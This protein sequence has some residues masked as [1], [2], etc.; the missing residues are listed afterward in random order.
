MGWGRNLLPVVVV[1]EK[2]AIGRF[3][4]IRGNVWIGTKKA[5]PLWRGGR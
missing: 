2:A 5:W 1:T 3:N 4:G